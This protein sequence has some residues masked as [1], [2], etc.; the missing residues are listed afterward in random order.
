VSIWGVNFHIVKSALVAFPFFFYLATRFW[1]AT[2]AYFLVYLLQSKRRGQSGSVGVQ[3]TTSRRFGGLSILSAIIVA[4]CLVFFYGLQTKAIAENAVNAAF[5]TATFIFWVPL[6]TRLLNPTSKVSHSVLV[7]IAVSLIGLALNEEMTLSNFSLNDAIGLAGA[8]AL[9]IEVTVLAEVA[10]GANSLVLMKWTATY[11]ALIA[12]AFTLAAAMAG[13]APNTADF[14]AGAIGAL[15]FT[16]ILATAVA[17][18]LANWANSVCT[19]DGTQVITG[20]HRAIMENLDA[21]IA[22]V[23]SLTLALQ[24]EDAKAHRIAGCIVITLG[25]LIA[26]LDLV[27]RL[28]SRFNSSSQSDGI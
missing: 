6:F 26:E 27:G 1:I 15:C 4:T 22:L 16:G 14:T 2:V 24:P 12:V 18:Y 19:V 10:K 17:N 28:F 21:P 13:T 3:Y 7:G 8:I 11:T 9:A 20:V 5:L 25:V 23:M